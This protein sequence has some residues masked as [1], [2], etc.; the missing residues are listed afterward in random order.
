[1]LEERRANVARHGTC[2]RPDLLRGTKIHERV[3]EVTG[4]QG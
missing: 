2:Q 1:M 4:T 3:H